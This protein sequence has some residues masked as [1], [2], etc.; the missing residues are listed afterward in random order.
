MFETKVC[1]RCEKELTIGMF[2][3]AKKNKDGLS[4]WYK[5]CLNEYAEKRKNPLRKKRIKVITNPRMRFCYKCKRELTFYDFNKDKSAPSGYNSCCKEC[6]KKKYK[7]Y[8]EYN[9]DKIKITRNIYINQNI[10]KIKESQRKYVTK[11][12]LNF[13]FYAQKRRAMKE[14]LP[15]TL[16]EQQWELI[17]QQF[18][19][20]C[21]YC[22][23][24]LPLA[25]DHFLALSKGGEYTINNIIPSCQSCNSSKRDKDFFMWYPKHKSYSKKREDF[26]LKYLNYNKQNIQQLSIL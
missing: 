18:D 14:L 15:S 13:V 9:F 7:T 3:N 6:Q 17:K 20:K 4:T 23:K 19:N 25:Q 22:G 1:T 26:I 24:G 8:Y 12:H 2:G 11:H 16:N 5:K 10:L 21:A